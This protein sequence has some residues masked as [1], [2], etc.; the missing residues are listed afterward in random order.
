M[1]YNTVTVTGKIL[2]GT[3][4][5]SGRAVLIPTVNTVSDLDGNV[6]IFGALEAILA[7][8]GSFSIEA[9]ATDDANLRP[10]NFGYTLRF[11]LNE[12][13]IPPIPEFSL[14]TAAVSIDITDIIPE[15]QN[16]TF[17]PTL[18]GPPNELTVTSVTTGAPGSAAQVIINGEPPN[19]TIEFVLPQGNTGPIGPANTLAVGTVTTGAAGTPADADITGVAPNQILDLVIPQGLQ[20]QQGIQG[21]QGAPGEV[22]TQQLNDGLATKVSKVGDTLT[23]NLALKTY[24][25]SRIDHSGTTGAKTIDWDTAAIHTLGLAGNI[26]LSFSNNADGDSI[27]LHINAWYGTFAMTWPAGV[28]WAGGSAPTL[29]ANKHHLITFMQFA[30][31][32][33]GIY[34]GE[35]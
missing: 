17:V 6:L 21:P 33:W 9:P 8:D 34:G 25:E 4:P 19:Q 18:T 2:R 3:A 16:P 7:T 23:G 24:S 31:T 20:G 22:S 5:A 27:L 1:V 10:Q 29:T 35:F 28:V 14:P 12:G 32:T 30:G 26:T 15:P 11:D 13:A